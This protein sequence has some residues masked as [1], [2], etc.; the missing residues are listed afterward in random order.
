MRV[1]LFVG[2][3]ANDQTY[4][5]SRLS[6]NKGEDFLVKARASFLWAM[7][8]AKARPKQPFSGFLG[9]VSNAA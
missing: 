2:D 8:R 4:S 3:D 7:C 1:L 6:E 5:K 9:D